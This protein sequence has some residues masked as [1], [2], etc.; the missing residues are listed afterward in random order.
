MRRADGRRRRSGR[1]RREAHV[2]PEDRAVRALR[3]STAGPWPGAAVGI[4]TSGTVIGVPLPAAFTK[5]KIGAP[6][7][8]ICPMIKREPLIATGVAAGGEGDPRRAEVDGLGERRLDRRRRVG[9]RDVQVEEQRGV[10]AAR[11]R[12]IGSVA[13]AVESGEHGGHGDLRGERVGRHVGVRD[14]DARRRAGTDRRAEEIDAAAARD[15]LVRDEAEAGDRDGRGRRVLRVVR[16]E[17]DDAVG[18]ADE[19]ERIHRREAAPERAATADLRAD[20]EL[21]RSVLVRLRRRRTS[22]RPC[23]TPPSCT[24]A[25]DRPGRRRPSEE[26]RTSR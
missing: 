18:R 24:P 5:P 1:S 20:R 26:R 8:L 25:G 4:G 15:D 6:P 12:R 13:G 14:R 19:H 22:A 21:R 7:A 11:A 17:R 3:R 23:R 16:G 9:G 10:V 2:R